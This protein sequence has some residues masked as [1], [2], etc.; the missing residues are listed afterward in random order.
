[1]SCTIVITS[2]V[3]ADVQTMALATCVVCEV[4]KNQTVA[5]SSRPSVKDNENELFLWL[6]KQ[7][8]EQLK[9]KQSMQHPVFVMLRHCLP[10]HQEPHVFYVPRT[11]TV[12]ECVV[13][14]QQ[15]VQTLFNSFEAIRLFFVPEDVFVVVNTTDFLSFVPNRHADVDFMIKQLS[16]R[17]PIFVNNLL[18]PCRT[19]FPVSPFY[20][21]IQQQNS[22]AQNQRNRP[23]CIVFAPTLPNSKP[24]NKIKFQSSF[25]HPDFASFE[26]VYDPTE[27]VAAMDPLGEVDYVAVVEPFKPPLPVEQF[28]SNSAPWFH[29]PPII[30]DLSK[31]RFPF[32]MFVVPL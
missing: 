31:T 17:K 6:S 2:K 28:V 16:S 5:R 10:G 12:A 13:A 29:S 20:P 7:K 32:S 15:L 4:E 8:T 27:N 26:T 30:F 14:A 22:K 18:D 24:A 1:M 25:A 9:E 11:A 3:G 21:K 19:F 23:F